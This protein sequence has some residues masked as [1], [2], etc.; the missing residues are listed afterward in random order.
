M[1]SRFWFRHKSI[2]Y[3]VTP[4]TWQ[5]WLCILALV[6]V[7]AATL[8]LLGDPLGMHVGAGPFLRLRTAL[9]LG[10]LNIPFAWRVVIAAAEVVLFMMFAR[11]RTAPDPPLDS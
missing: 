11:G 4:A 6:V 7:I 8:N 10:G 9:G 5:G 2:G 1:S 3:G